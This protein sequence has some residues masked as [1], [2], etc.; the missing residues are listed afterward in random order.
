VVTFAATI[1]ATAVSWATRD[2]GNAL[3]HFPLVCASSLTT[4]SIST[5]AIGLL[6]IV[7]TLVATRFGI[8]P[9]NI[10]TPIASALGTTNQ[11]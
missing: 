6:L 7:M 5:L 9:D 3:A 2:D 4:S 1:A 8:N 10:G 11:G